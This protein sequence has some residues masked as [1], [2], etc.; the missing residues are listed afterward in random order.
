MR[1]KLERQYFGIYKQGDLW[2]AEIFNQ[3]IAAS[4]NVKESSD[5]ARAGER[6]LLKTCLGEVGLPTQSV[7]KVLWWAISSQARHISFFWVGRLDTSGGCPSSVLC[8]Q[9]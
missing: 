6:Q 1:P 3:R 5:Q 4:T 7:Q 2:V 8:L 9:D